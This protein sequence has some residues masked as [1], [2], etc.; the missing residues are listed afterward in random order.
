MQPNDIFITYRHFRLTDS[1]GILPKGGATL[2][3][4]ADLRDPNYRQVIV[5]YSLCSKHD[6]FNKAIGR[7][8]AYQNL[9]FARRELKRSIDAFD[10]NEFFLL[11]KEAGGTICT[12]YLDFLR[13]NISNIDPSYHEVGNL[14]RWC[15]KHN[16]L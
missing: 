9:N 13:T 16:I 1:V 7:N 8:L 2:A 5:G 6:H 14:L 10:F 15:N 11:P 4:F 12:Q 3:F